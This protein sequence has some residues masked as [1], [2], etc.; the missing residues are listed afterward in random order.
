MIESRRQK[1]LNEV[2][3]E[4]LPTFVYNNLVTEHF[5]LDTPSR[6][7]NEA[8]YDFAH[9]LRPG[10]DI[11]GAYTQDYRGSARFGGGGKV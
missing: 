1:L 5:D 10:L 9:S 3:I 6:A 4:L 2:K 8:C 11:H 7:F